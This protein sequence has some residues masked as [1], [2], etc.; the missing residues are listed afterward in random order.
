YGGLIYDAPL[1]RE[2]GEPHQGSLQ[3]FFDS[4]ATRLRYQPRWP[5]IEDADAFTLIRNTEVLVQVPNG[6]LYDQTRIGAAEVYLPADSHRL[7]VRAQMEG[8]AAD[9]RLALLESPIGQWL[10]EEFERWQLS[11]QLA[12]TLN[13]GID[14]D[15]I[16]RSQIRVDTQVSGGE[17]WSENLNLRITDI[18]GEIRYH[19]QH[20]LTAD[21]LSGRLFG[22]PLAAQ[23]DTQGQGGQAS[24]HI[25]GQGRVA[26]GAVRDWLSLPLLDAL[27]GETDY[28]FE[29]RI[30]GYRPGCSGLNISSDL[31]GVALEAP[32]PFAKQA[33]DPSPFRLDLALTPDQQWLS[34]DTAGIDA[35]LALKQGALLGGNVVFGE[36]QRPLPRRVDGIAIR[37]HV[38][39]LELEAWQTFVEQR[40]LNGESLFRAWGGDEASDDTVQQGAAIRVID[41]HAEQATLGDHQLR[42][43]HAMLQE[44]DT[45][46]SLAVNS[47]EVIGQWQFAVGEHPHQVHLQRLYL[48]AAAAAALPSDSQAPPLPEVKVDPWQSYR[49]Q[50]FPAA[51]VVIEDLR[52]GDKAYGRWQFT[53]DPVADGARFDAVKGQINGLDVDGALVWLYRDGQHRT[54]L[55]LKAVTADIGAVMEGWGSARSMSTEQA[56]VEAHIDWNGSPS[57]F[58]WAILN[59]EARIHA[60]RGRLFDTGDRAVVKL[61]SLFNMNTLLRRLSLDF[62]DLSAQGTFFDE[63]NAQLALRDGIASLTEPA[64][65][66][67]PTHDIEVEGDIDLG[68][69]FFDLQLLVKLPVADNLP[70]AAALL[71]TPAV[72]G[73]VFLVERLIGKS[74]KRFTSV[75]YQL[76]GPWRE[77]VMEPLRRPANTNPPTLPLDSEL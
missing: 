32:Q 59:G 64:T 65:L 3:M 52:R 66:I 73:A 24:T 34:I 50:I 13:L 26:L 57:G 37:G 74:L 61:F 36:H 30:C 9:G 51:E 20:G 62:D 31:V 49:P 29:L 67:S 17:Y 68:Q 22:L 44:G 42:R 60:E 10:G 1:R 8:P 39:T 11:G 55:N 28:A 63:I 58:D 69:E 71:A 2:A 56:E 21:A 19:E 15:A 38:A 6:R 14:M 18:G 25:R 45:G 40:F 70:I 23:I 33:A 27:Q 76:T 47:D 41:L 53:L 5:A 46:W 48:P 43:A 77:P 12:T 35:L 7:Q 54:E 72:A 16:E 4:T 75:R